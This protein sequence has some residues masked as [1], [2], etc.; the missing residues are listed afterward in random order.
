[1]SALMTNPRAGSSYHFR[2]SLGA[3]LCLSFYAVLQAEDCNW[4]GTLDA[5]DLAGGSS[6][7]CNG[8]GVPD[9]CDVNPFEFGHPIQLGDKFE[10]WTVLLRTVHDLNGDGEL[11]LIGNGF[12]PPRP[13]GYMQ[14]KLRVLFNGG[15]G[16]F[17]SAVDVEF[18]RV[19]GDVLAGDL[20]GD[21]DADLI[22]I[23]AIFPEYSVGLNRGD[24][25]FERELQVSLGTLDVYPLTALGD[26]D[27]DGDADLLLAYHGAPP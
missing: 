1:M 3:A 5:T 18:G 12:G 2:F 25:T 8:N 13:D 23:S 10:E 9:E 19:T 14:A 20:D 24:G 26:F 11:D 16:A 17:K 6:K 27:G 7:D 15:D 4:N 21:G 22:S